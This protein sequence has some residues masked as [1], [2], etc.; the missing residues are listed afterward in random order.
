MV[1][2][3]LKN[4]R[5]TGALVKENRL[6]VWVRLK[7]SEVIKRHKMKHNVLY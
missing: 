6:T 7:D 1:E 3:D 4:E 2:F 5:S